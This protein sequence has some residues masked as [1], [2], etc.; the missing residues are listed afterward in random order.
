MFQ[1]CCCL[2]S[3]ERDRSWQDCEVRDRL[4]VDVAHGW[5]LG[6]TLRR[7]LRL[8][9]EQ[10]EVLNGKLTEMGG[11]LNTFVWHVNSMRCWMTNWLRW[12]A[13]W[14]NVWHVRGAECG[15]ASWTLSFDTSTVWGAEWQTN[16]DG[17]W[18]EHFRLTR[19]QYEVL[20]DKLTEMGGELNTFVWHVNSMRCWMTNWLRWVASW[21]LSF[22]TSTVWGAEWQ[23]NWDGWRVEHF[24]LTRQQYEVLN[25]KLTEM[26]GE[27][28]T[29]VWHVNS[30]RCWM[31]N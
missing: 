5:Q 11:E 8:T 14:T 20:N 2:P 31:A 7:H 26:G 13:S 27:L 18:V 16:W 4:Q 25:D 29:F 19:Q 10:Y 23:T 9:R 3:A 17:W 6:K 30:M 1:K 22:D 28:N 12:V 15:E 21:T 24:R